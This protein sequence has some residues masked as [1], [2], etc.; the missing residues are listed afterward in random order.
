MEVLRVATTKKELLE[1]LENIAI[2]E[3]PN[4]IRKVWQLIEV[5]DYLIV[6]DLYREDPR[7]S[8]AVGIAVVIGVPVLVKTESGMFDGLA[9]EVSGDHW[10]EVLSQAVAG[11]NEIYRDTYEV[12]SGG[13]ECLS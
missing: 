1:G 11:R 3:L 6:E 5:S 12:H 2:L 13:E 8:I 9:L 7:A 10:S 4:E